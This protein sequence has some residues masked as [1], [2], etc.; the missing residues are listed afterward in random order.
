MQDGSTPQTETE[1]AP[2]G[3][4]D[5]YTL[6]NV[7]G[8]R[9]QL[10]QLPNYA[11]HDLPEHI[12]KPND[13]RMELTDIGATL[14]RVLFYDKRLSV[15]NTISCAS[16][17]Q[18]S[19]AFSDANRASIGVHGTTGRHSM[20]IVNI[21]YG[22]DQRF[23]WDRRA[24]SLEHQSTE[25]I[26]DHIEMG[27]SGKPGSPNLDDLIEK[28]Q[29]LPYYNELFTA[30][31]GDPVITEERMQGAL[32]QFMRSII[33]FDARYDEGR[34][35]V[36]ND[37]EP[38]PNFSAQ[39]NLGKSL[40]IQDGIFNASGIRIGGGLGCGSCH[41]PPL[42]DIDPAS[43]NNGVMG[44]LDGSGPDQTNTRSPSLRDVVKA[45]GSANGPFMHNALSSDMRTVL[46]HY[47]TMGMQRMNTIIDPRLRPNGMP[48]RLAMTQEETDA[49]I[50]FLKTLAGV[51][52]YRAE[53]W[54]N[55]FA[56]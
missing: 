8:D 54:S 13:V 48:Q 53:R 28:L 17:H 18:Q 45:D 20:R 2:P 40:F 9:I 1:I 47:G 33:S 49:V 50:A 7:F 10:D 4:F 24:P 51:E 5:Q 29:M 23:F 56:E 11:Q 36:I 46:Q 27:F 32:S 15:N 14:G 39:E 31:F 55:P 12:D 30:A 52:I 6:R 41:R 34:A 35:Q 43:L 37:L 26:Q 44:S 25:P 38:F 19:L 16:C 42:F 3:A 21:G 22:E